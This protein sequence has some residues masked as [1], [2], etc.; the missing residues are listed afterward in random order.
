MQGL[1]P[2]ALK[3][4]GHMHT[5]KVAIVPG[6][7]PE[8]IISGTTLTLDQFLY[9]LEACNN[10]RL[11]SVRDYSDRTQFPNRAGA[12]EFVAYCVSR[13]WAIPAREGAQNEPA[14]WVSGN[15]RWTVRAKFGTL[16]GEYDG[17]PRAES[18]QEG[19]YDGGGQVV[20]DE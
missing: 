4:M 13:G 3:L 9:Y 8:V 10:F 16:L 17:I 20:E 15:N 6:D 1:D 11:I 7:E 19:A 12:S 5:L 14:M 18:T 2:E